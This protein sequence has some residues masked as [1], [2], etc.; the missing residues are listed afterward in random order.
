M[1]DYNIESDN[2]KI[3]LSEILLKYN[4]KTNNT[5]FRENSKKT[6]KRKNDYI[7]EENESSMEIFEEEEIE[8][9]LKYGKGNRKIIYKNSNKKNIKNDKESK[10]QN[11]PNNSNKINEINEKDKN[12][13]ANRNLKKIIIKKN[14]INKKKKINLDQ[15]DIDK[16]FDFNKFNYNYS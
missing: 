11:S 13:I 10:I 16:E 6:I 5:L 15:I 1:N 9:I 8:G 4:D 3:Q 2:D 14:N 12:E 7:I